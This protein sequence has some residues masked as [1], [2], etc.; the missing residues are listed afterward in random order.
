[1]PMTMAAQQI[2][3]SRR[4]MDATLWADPDFSYDILEAGRV[5]REERLGQDGV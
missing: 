4:I 2:C 3:P 1:M 5:D